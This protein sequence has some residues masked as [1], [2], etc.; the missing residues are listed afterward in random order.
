MTAEQKAEQTRRRNSQNAGGKT[1]AALKMAQDARDKLA[2][3]QKLIVDL[4][5]RCDRLQTLVS[6]SDNSK[7]KTQNSKLVVASVTAP[8]STWLVVMTTL[9]PVQMICAPRV[10]CRASS[11][12]RATLD[13]RSHAGRARS[14]HRT[15]P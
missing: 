6:F 8:V 15:W 12:T 4:E 10:I 3:A 7:L 13:P 5:A 14:L 2:E 9:R 1:R 11:A